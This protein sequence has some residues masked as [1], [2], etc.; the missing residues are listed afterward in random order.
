MKKKNG[1]GK[2][3]DSFIRLL[4]NK[5]YAKARRTLATVLAGIVVF[6]TTYLLILPALTVDIGSVD[7]VGMIMPMAE[8]NLQ[9]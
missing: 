8:G 1:F 6:T 9:E 7:E 3:I 4:I 2:L 5:R